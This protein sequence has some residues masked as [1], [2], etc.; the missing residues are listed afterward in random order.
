MN[1]SE[2]PDNCIPVKV[3]ISQ[4][5]RFKHYKPS[6]SQFKAGI[7]GRWQ[8]FDGYGWSNCA[9]PDSWEYPKLPDQNKN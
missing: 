7:V 6:S 5:M 9:A 2:N 8:E 4:T 3:V 1:R